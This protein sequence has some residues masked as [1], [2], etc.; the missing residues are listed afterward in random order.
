MT[1]ADISVEVVRKSCD[2]V[3]RK[4]TQ[5]KGRITDRSGAAER[6]IISSSRIQKERHQ[7]ETL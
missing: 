7:H 4:I 1:L 5:K 6:E 2:K 3:Y